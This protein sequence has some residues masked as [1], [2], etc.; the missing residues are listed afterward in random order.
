MERD[1][2]LLLAGKYKDTIF[3]VALNMLA[4]P[5]EAED[6]VQEV[7]LRLLE[8]GRDF[9]SEEHAR[10]WLVRVTINLCKNTLRSPWRK[11]HVPLTAA[12]A[13]PAFEER[14]QSE[15]YST[16]MA[17]PEKYR[18]V[19]YLFYYEG[20]SVKEIAKLTGSGVSAVTTRL[21]R[22]REMIRSHFTEAEVD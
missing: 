20:Y 5:H 22:A 11:R 3:R 6:A 16:V 2:F 1:A 17:L 13:L 21:S 14:E 18:T 12:E 4:S 8:R 15:L 7:L 19:L 10:F 9:E